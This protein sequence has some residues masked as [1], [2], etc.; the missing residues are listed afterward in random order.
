[1]AL[2]GEFGF[3]GLLSPVA[4]FRSFEKVPTPKPQGVWSLRNGWRGGSSESHH[5]REW[6]VWFIGVCL[7]MTV[8]SLL[9][10]DRIIA[11]ARGRFPHETSHNTMSYGVCRLLKEWGRPSFSQIEPFCPYC[12]SAVRLEAYLFKGLQPTPARPT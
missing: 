5:N 2:G 6:G 8:P 1:M 9:K 12:V 3:G 11:Q 4:F 7:G 10:D